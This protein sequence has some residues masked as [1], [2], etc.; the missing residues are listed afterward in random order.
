VHPRRRAG[1]L[2]LRSRL[3]ASLPALDGEVA[4]AALD[5]PVEI[6][7]DEL[8]VPTVRATTRLD[9]ARAL[10]FLH[11]QERFFQMDL[12]RRKSAGELAGDRR[13][14]RGRSRPAGAPPSLPRPCRC[15]GR[16]LGAEGREI[17]AAY[18]AE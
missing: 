8:G 18:A 4:V 11:G 6:E 13:P 7:R 16:P 14:G 9:A 1:A 15:R 3:V 2:W 12:L 5:G 17:V 10:G